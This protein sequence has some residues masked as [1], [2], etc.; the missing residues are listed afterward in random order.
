MLSERLLQ[1]LEQ[2]L[3]LSAPMCSTC[4]FEPYCGADPV[5]HH[6]TMDDFVG[7]KAMSA[8]C[9]RNMGVFTAILRRAT[10]GHLRPGTVLPVGASMMKLMGRATPIGPPVLID[11][12][13]W[14]VC[15]SGED[16][17][18]LPLA[19]L[20]A[21]GEA[22]ASGY[23]LVPVSQH[24]TSMFPVPLS[25]C[26]PTWTTLHQG[27][28]IGIAPDGQRITVLWKEAA[29]HNSVLL[30]EQCDNYC[31]MCSQPPK[32]REDAWLF[33]RAK[34][35]VSLLPPSARGLGLTGGEPTLASRTRLLTSSSIAATRHPGYRC[36]CS[37][38]AGGSLTLI[39]RNGIAAGWPRRPH[40]WYP[41]STRRKPACMTS[42]S[43]LRARSRRRSAG[44]S[45]SCPW[46]RAS[47]S[48]S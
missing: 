28:I 12:G 13:V 30:T 19:C 25:G 48:V 8:F 26:P 14:R 4:A 24:R 9:Q 35:I 17:A 38:T 43:R 34:R 15:R 6:T 42:S 27:D 45:T 31:L 39:S 7:Q 5:F 47:S 46:D 32:D 41:A 3:T 22:P 11:P 20:L 21:D 33:E 40:G 23:R 2:S 18:D 36:T 37:R 29:A 1:P 10:Q 16:S 44:F